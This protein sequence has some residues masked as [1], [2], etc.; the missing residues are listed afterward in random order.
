[1][2]IRT[3]WQSGNN[4]PNIASPFKASFFLNPNCKKSSRLGSGANHCQP[5]KAMSTNLRG[6][7]RTLLVDELQK[8]LDDLK[9]YRAGEMTENADSSRAAE[10]AKRVELARGK[11][12][13]LRRLQRREKDIRDRKR[14]IEQD[15]AR[16]D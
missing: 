12:D 5:Q 15:N 8:L 16:R 2:K 6:I 9:S 4:S 3:S 1:M 7:N 14:K 10:M 13:D 11:L